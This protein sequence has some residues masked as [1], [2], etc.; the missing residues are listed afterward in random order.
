V[1]LI[2]TSNAG[3]QYI[4]DE[5]AKGTELSTIKEALLATELRS[6]FRP[7]FLNRFNDVIVFAPLTEADVTAIAY[8]LVEKVKKQIEAKGMTL[9]VTDAAIHEL[10]RQG[11]DP[12]FGARPLRRTI[13][14]KLENKL[15]D[16]LLKGNIS[17]RDAVVFDVG[18][19]I[20]VRKA[21]KL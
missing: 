4:Q 19:K 8:L 6:L 20:E 10:G 21:Q 13:E 2:A 12:K 17:R 14:E 18:G 15:A 11:F 7:E 9:E 16:E 3:T 5:V 1:I